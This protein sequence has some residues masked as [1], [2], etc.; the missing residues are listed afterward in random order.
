MDHL[1]DTFSRMDLWKIQNFFLYDVA[2]YF[3]F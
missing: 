2:C 3:K 1:K